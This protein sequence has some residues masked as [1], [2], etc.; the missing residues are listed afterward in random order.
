M[1]WSDRH[2]HGHHSTYNQRK[3]LSNCERAC[4]L[5]FM[6]G[7][8]CLPTFDWSI[9]SAISEQIMPY[10]SCTANSYIYLHP[11]LLDRENNILRYSNFSGST[12]MHALRIIEMRCDSNAVQPCFLHTA[13]CPGTLMS[14]SLR[15][16]LNVDTVS[17]ARLRKASSN[18]PFIRLFVAR[19][20]F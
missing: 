19:Y 17:R 1:S 6:F 12:R 18:F 4:W 10:L 13:V 8:C 14:A 11:P 15:W 2:E 5:L 9:S 16:C 7:L 3:K 20:P